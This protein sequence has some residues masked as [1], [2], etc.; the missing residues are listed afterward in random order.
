M[1]F[2]VTPFFQ[3][4]SDWNSSI[5]TFQLYDIN[6]IQAKTIAYIRKTP[7]YVL[8]D[9][10]TWISNET[11]I[12]CFGV[13]DMRLWPLSFNP[14]LWP[15]KSLSLNCFQLR[16][17]LVLEWQKWA[18]TC[19]DSITILISQYSNNVTPLIF[20]FLILVTN[21]NNYNNVMSICDPANITSNRQEL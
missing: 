14:L 19:L 10:K 15:G 21:L 2:F 3:P 8:F 5:S 20:E 11:S 6:F 9:G 17:L 16:V 13:G 7:L 18:A 12:L 1:K 4:K